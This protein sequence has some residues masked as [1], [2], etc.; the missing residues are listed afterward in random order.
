MSL[1]IGPVAYLMTRSIYALLNTRQYWCQL[2]TLSPEVRRELSFW[3]I[4]ISC[5]NGQGIWHSPSAVRVVYSDA[6]DTG[7]RGFT[8][9]H[10][11]YAA[12]G[13][14]SPEEKTKS[15]TWRE[16]RAV[17]M[18]LESLIP[19][20]KNERIC[21]FSDNQNVVRILEIGIK[22]P[23]L[24]EETQE[25]G[26]PLENWKVRNSRGWPP[27]FQLQLCSVKPH[28]PPRSTLDRSSA[29][30]HGQPHIT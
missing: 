5:I 2:L 10:G 1:A 23:S 7:Y 6:S 21:W 19:K 26:N 20:L 9:E 4:Q 16:L 30:S 17:R 3:Q 13:D 18:L 25:Y 27:H 8:V 29:G 28:P 15:S 11:C 22:N 12:R 24:Q 14:W